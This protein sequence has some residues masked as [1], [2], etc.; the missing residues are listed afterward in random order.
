MYEIVYA[1][2]ARARMSPDQLAAILAVSRV[3]NS[4]LGVTGILLFHEGSF[5]QVLE[6]E[7]ATV[8]ELYGRI[9][10][11]PRHDRCAELRKGAIPA[12]SFSA[13]SMGFVAL[14]PLLLTK[15]VGRHAF[16]SNGSLRSDAASVLELLDA[17]RDGRYRRYILA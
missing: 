5:F 7:Q 4:R 2:A 10:R 15:L 17:F 13:W 11:D 1:S 9:A 3:N 16:T 14:D 8:E 12:P 6:G